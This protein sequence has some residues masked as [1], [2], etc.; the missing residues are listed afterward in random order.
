GS[1]PSSDWSTSSL[2]SA[3]SPDRRRA[4]ACAGLWTEPRRTFVGVTRCATTASAPIPRILRE[5]GVAGE[6]RRQPDAGRSRDRY[7]PPRGRRIGWRHGWPDGVPLGERRRPVRGELGGHSPGQS[8]TPVNAG[9]LYHPGPMRETLEREIKL[10]A[11][12][13]F[14]LPAMPGAEIDRV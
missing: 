10:Q 6:G 1:I 2:P 8:V 13:D 5:S 4:S 14:E 11:P 3:T 7:P 12:G 9:F